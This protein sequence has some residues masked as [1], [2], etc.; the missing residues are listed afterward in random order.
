MAR[1]YNI[2]LSEEEKRLK[3]QQ[4]AD[5]AAA[6]AVFD[7]NIANANKAYDKAVGDT[8]LSYEDAYRQN[9]VQRL[10]NERTIAEN[11]ANM[12]LTDSGLNR[13]QMTA[14]QLSYANQ[15]GRLD[16][17]K[18]SAVDELTFNL[19]QLV[20]D[21]TAQKTAS[22]AEIDS[23][24]KQ[25]AAS[26]ANQIYKAELDA[27]AENTKNYYSYLTSKTTNNQYNGLPTATQYNQAME[28]YNEGKYYA[29]EQLIDDNCHN[30]TAE[31]LAHWRELIKRIGDRYGIKTSSGF[32]I[33]N[34][35]KVSIQ[36]ALAALKRK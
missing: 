24:Y 27:D 12:G 19:A 28:Y 23:S 9:E 20:S 8:K 2:I 11:M 7:T 25:L 36:N 30:M 14:S 31:Q 18:Q 4:E 1:D 34:Q 33:A 5:K 16:R 29:L 21:Y 17:Q 6:G 26:N 13:T 15:K 22:L 10:V 3:A 35:M 32:G